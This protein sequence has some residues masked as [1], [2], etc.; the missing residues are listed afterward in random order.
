MMWCIV[1]NKPKQVFMIR[2]N[3][4]QQFFP[5]EK[6]ITME[7][8]LKFIVLETE[9]LFFMKMER[10]N[11]PIL[12]PIKLFLPPKTKQNYLIEEVW[13]ILVKQDI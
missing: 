12:V 6:P 3:W 11:L 9:E 5:K 10:S 1:N 8:M 7:E 13:F 4:N 2:G